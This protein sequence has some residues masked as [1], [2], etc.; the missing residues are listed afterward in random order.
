V[1]FAQE[2][3]GRYDVFDFLA[4]LFVVCLLPPAASPPNTDAILPRMPRAHS[5]L[6]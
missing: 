3:F 5:R 1:R 4:V 6:S 2:R